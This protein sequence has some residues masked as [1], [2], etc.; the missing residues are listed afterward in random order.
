M[1]GTF[2][3]GLGIIPAIKKELK[4]YDLFLDRHRVLVLNYKFAMLYFGS[5][6]YS[7]S[8]DYLQKIINDNTNLRYDLQCYARLLHLMAI[9]S[10]AMIC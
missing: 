6:D 1:Q 7:T 9:M 10:W 4:G 5:G 2:K 8:I 3:E